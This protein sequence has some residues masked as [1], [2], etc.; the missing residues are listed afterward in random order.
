MRKL[1]LAALAAASCVV[2]AADPAGFQLW[3]V[4]DLKKTEKALGAKL[5]AHKAASEQ[6]AKMDGY[7]F[8]LAHREG[9]GTAELHVKMADIFVVQAG[10]ATLVVGG[11]LSGGQDAGPHEMRGSGIEGGEKHKLVV[12]DVVTIPANTPHQ[13]LLDAGKQFTYFVVKVESK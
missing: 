10:E 13:L 7:S 5:D 12:G 2:F 1:L 11:K 6:L 3:K 4:A 8:M 9:P